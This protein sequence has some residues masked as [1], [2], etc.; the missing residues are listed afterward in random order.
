[1][2][3][4]RLRDCCYYPFEKHVSIRMDSLQTTAIIIRDAFHAVLHFAF[5]IWG[6]ISGGGV[7]YQCSPGCPQITELKQTIRQICFE[8]RYG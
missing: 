5:F 3:K 7:E 8:T 6:Y 2:E 1:M 4:N